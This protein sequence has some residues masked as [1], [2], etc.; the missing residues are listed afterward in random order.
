ML[1][2]F[3]DWWQMSLLLRAKAKLKREENMQRLLGSCHWLLGIIESSETIS[4]MSTQFCLPLLPITQRASVSDSI[5]LFDMH[6]NTF[7]RIPAKEMGSLDKFGAMLYRSSLLC[8]IRELLHLIRVFSIDRGK[9]L[10]GPRR[11][12]FCSAC[13]GGFRCCGGFFRSVL[14]S[15]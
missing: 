7:A 12:S 10:Q 15:S 13:S 8:S 14:L 9:L 3:L 2:A 6:D 5:I 4:C 1:D 11:N